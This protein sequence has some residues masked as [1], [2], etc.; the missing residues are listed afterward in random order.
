MLTKEAY[1]ATIAWSK[2]VGACVIRDESGKYLIVQEAN[3]KVYGL[4]NLAAGH[5]DKDETIEAA[6]IREAKEEVGLDVELLYKVG[7]WHDNV[8]EPIRHVFMTK[9]IGGEVTSQLGELLDAR[10]FTYDE[11]VELRDQGKLRGEWIFEAISK[12]ENA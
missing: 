4:W 10:Y 6:A 1:E 3:P 11:I 12:V 7:L 5:V 8:E 9:V 2:I